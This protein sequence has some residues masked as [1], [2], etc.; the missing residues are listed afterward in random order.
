MIWI[1][2]EYDPSE[3]VS[4]PVVVPVE[5]T[6]VAAV[7]DVTVCVPRVT[8]ATPERVNG[9]GPGRVRAR[10][11]ERDVGQ[12]DWDKVR[13]DADPGEAANTVPVADAV[14]LLSVTVRSCS[15]RWHPN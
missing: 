14:A 12:T 11:G 6:I 5:T 10:Q 2:V 8:P 9:V 4:V 15:G 13:R 1:D 3:R 7:V